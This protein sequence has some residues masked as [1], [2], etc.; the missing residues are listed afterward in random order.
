MN[1]LTSFVFGV[2]AEGDPMLKLWL[3]RRI[4]RNEQKHSEMFGNVK[5][6]S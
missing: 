6:L 3:K 1:E 2:K 4:F 5:I